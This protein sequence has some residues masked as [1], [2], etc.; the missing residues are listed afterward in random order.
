MNRNGMILVPWAEAEHWDFIDS[1]GYDGNCS[2]HISPPC[3]SCT[4]PGNPLN[5]E[6]CDEAWE[7]ED[8]SDM[9]DEMEKEALERLEK[10]INQLTE[11][12]L[13]EAKNG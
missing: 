1:Y 3:G 6:E 4:H 13:K 2:C 10:F 11:K 5:L 9:L 12:H 7:R 8:I